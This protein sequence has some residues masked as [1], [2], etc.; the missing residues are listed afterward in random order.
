MGWI[1]G[2]SVVLTVG[3]GKKNMKAKLYCDSKTHEFIKEQ[4][5]DFI[6]KHEAMVNNNQYDEVYEKLSLDK[7]ILGLGSSALT[8]LLEENNIDVLSFL[9]NIPDYFLVNTDIQSFTIPDGFNSIGKEAF[10]DCR[11]LVTVIVPK[12]LTEVKAGAFQN[13]VNLKVIYYHGT[14]DEFNKITIQSDNQEFSKDK[15]QFI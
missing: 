15:V 8:I 13:C 14:P 11:D 3:G 5:H 7:K 6:D 12:T 2:Y 4:L 10:K 1:F 9:R